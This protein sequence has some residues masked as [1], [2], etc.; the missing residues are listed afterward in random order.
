MLNKIMQRQNK[1]KLNKES[2]LNRSKD[3]MDYKENERNV[4]GKYTKM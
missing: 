4:D 2:E 1:H 3:R